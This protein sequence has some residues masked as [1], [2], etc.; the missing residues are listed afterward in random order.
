MRV[1]KFGGKS[2]SSKEKCYNICKYIKE[3]HKKDQNIV[4]VVSAI[5]NT[6]DELLC[7]ANNYL[8]YVQ[9]NFLD[10]KNNF[11]ILRRPLQR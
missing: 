5:N 9:T 6:T 2:L 3:I 11:N 10:K 7:T 8:E 1:L 4:V